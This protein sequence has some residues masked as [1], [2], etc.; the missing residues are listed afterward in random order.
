MKFQFA[1]LLLLAVSFFSNVFATSSHLVDLAARHTKYPVKATPGLYANIMA[2][3]E[4]QVYAKVFAQVSA[5]FCEKVSAHLDVKASLLGG[6]ITA[7]LGVSAVQK[8]AVKKLKIDIEAELK[9]K[10]KVQVFAKIE[11]YLK[12]QC[13][14]KKLTEKQLLKI[15]ISVEAKLKETLKVEL[16]KICANLKLASKAEVNIVLKK[17]AIDIPHIV[18]INVN[19]DFDAKAAIKASV[20]V[21]LKACVKLNATQ[22]AK[23]TLKAI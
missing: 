1:T 9:A 20:S 19:A 10:A 16:P 23:L 3:I 15:L 6:A 2:E 11:A 14:S 13:G 21:G 17:L 12:K 22:M 7:D 8:L 4:A 5:N 18:H